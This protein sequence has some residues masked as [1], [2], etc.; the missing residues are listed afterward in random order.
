MI[1]RTDILSHLEHNARTGALMGTKDYESKRAPFTREHSSDGNAEQY[2]DMGA[3]PFP[4]NNAGKQGDGG[5]DAR[6]GATKVNSMNSGENVTMVGGEE[7]GMR[8][9]NRE[10]EGTGNRDANPYAGNTRILIAP[11]GY[12]D[13]TAWFAV[14]D[15]LAMSKPINLQIRKQPTLETFDDL[16]AGDGG[17]R[18]FKYHARYTVFYGD[19]RLCLQGNT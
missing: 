18:Y 10:L 4:R 5:T 15:S 11:G 3:V 13:S 7:R 2:A 17:V 19:W 1:T 6:T 14:D 9:V 12:L 8:V 16:T